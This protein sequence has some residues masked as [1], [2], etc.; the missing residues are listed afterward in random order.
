VQALIFSVILVTSPTSVVAS[1]SPSRITFFKL[2]K[3]ISTLRA[4][5]YA[6][7]EGAFP[8][9]DVDR[10]SDHNWVSVPVLPCPFGSA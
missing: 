6:P 7:K 9:T 5:V 2:V 3:A 1:V 10:N 8:N 4:S